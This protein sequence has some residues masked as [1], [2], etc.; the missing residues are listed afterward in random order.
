MEMSGGTST[1][2][3]VIHPEQEDSEEVAN[4]TIIAHEYEEDDSQQE[5]F[6]HPAT[7]AAADTS[8][9]SAGS[10]QWATYAL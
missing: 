1:G 6:I 7:A 10:G 5:D 9:G 2:S 3:I 4:G 8:F